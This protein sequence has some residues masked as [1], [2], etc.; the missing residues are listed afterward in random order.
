MVQRDRMFITEHIE[1]L[2]VNFIGALWL[3]ARLGHAVEIQRL[4]QAGEIKRAIVRDQR[5]AFDIATNLWPD[6]IEERRT[7]GIVL[8]QSMHIGIP[9]AVGILRWLH[10]EAQLLDD[11]PLLNADES[12]LAN[13]GARR[14]R[15]FKINRGKG[16]HSHHRATRI[17]LRQPLST[18]KMAIQITCLILTAFNFDALM[19]LCERPSH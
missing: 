1:L 18:A 15:R 12:D 5:A 19:L 3:V 13:T 14:L 10:Q 11:L 8:G 4:A 9:V 6:G 2:F 17:L 7:H 16:R